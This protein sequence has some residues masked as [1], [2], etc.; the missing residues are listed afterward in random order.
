PRH[1][2]E[3]PHQHVVNLLGEHEADG[4]HHRESDQRLDQPR[5]QLDQVI[6]QRRFGGLDVL[7]AHAAPSTLGLGGSRSRASS[8]TGS[9]A[10]GAKSALLTGGNG[11]G[12]GTEIS[13]SGTSAAG[14]VSAG[15]SVNA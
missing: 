11:S 6:H 3:G 4:E 10:G 1:Q 14:G 9:G 13:G 15:F 8:F 7:V 5:A 2:H 12:S